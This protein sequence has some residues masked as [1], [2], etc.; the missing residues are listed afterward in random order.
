MAN[1]WIIDVLLDLQSFARLNELAE[2]DRQLEETLAVARQSL[3]EAVG[4]D[5]GSM[6]G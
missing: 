5:G 3:S 6:L 2:L 1:G 4:G